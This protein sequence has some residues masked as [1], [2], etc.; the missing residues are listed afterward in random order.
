MSGIELAVARGNTLLDGLPDADLTE[1]LRAATRTDLPLGT[2]LYQ[3]GESV[4]AAPTA[5]SPMM[6][7]AARTAAGFG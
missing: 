5:M 6:P 3:P 1:L 7:S 2:V 4:A